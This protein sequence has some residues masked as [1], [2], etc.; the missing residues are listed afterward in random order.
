[1]ISIKFLFKD[2]KCGRKGEV[3]AS[4]IKSNQNI[5][6]SL[7]H[8][9]T[10]EL[11]SWQWILSNFKRKYLCSMGQKAEKNIPDKRFSFST[12]NQEK[13]FRPM[14]HFWYKKELLNCQ[15]SHLKPPSRDGR[16]TRL[17]TYTSHL[18][19][20]KWNSMTLG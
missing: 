9:V 16:F 3:P 18:F 4:S 7:I 19:L 6:S 1:M 17:R 8:R 12:A 14:L 20:Q 5:F 10:K 2:S 15:R 11:P 13:I